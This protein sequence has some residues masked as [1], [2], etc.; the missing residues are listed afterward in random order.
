MNTTTGVTFVIGDTVKNG[1]EKKGTE[2]GKKGREKEERE[3]NAY[4]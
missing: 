1:R 2:G 4:L 3:G